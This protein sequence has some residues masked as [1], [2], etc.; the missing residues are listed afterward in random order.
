MMPI[1]AGKPLLAAVSVIALAA[2]NGAPPPVL[3]EG[4]IP[5]LATHARVIGPAADYVEVEAVHSSPAHHLERIVLVDPAGRSIAAVEARADTIYPPPGAYYPYAPWAYAPWASVGVV[6]TSRG[7][8]SRSAVG[9]GF[10]FPLYVAPPPPPPLNR[11]R[12]TFKVPNPALYRREP[13]RWAIRLQF[14]HAQAGAVT[15][16]RPAPPP[17]P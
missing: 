12:A 17:S 11:L 14:N 1:A 5:G 4:G 9:V 2:C 8:Y 7:H 16:D 13:G 3:G 15:H 10:A 6:S